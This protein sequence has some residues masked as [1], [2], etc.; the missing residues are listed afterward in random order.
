VERAVEAFTVVIGSIQGVVI[1]GTV[2]EEL[3]QVLAE[4][5]IKQSG[6]NDNGARSG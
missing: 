1:V 3:D 4:V 2:I 6:G 5:I